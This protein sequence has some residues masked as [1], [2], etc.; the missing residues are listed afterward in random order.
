M[1]SSA[2]EIHFNALPDIT[3]Q[4]LVEAI[5]GRAEPK[6]ILSQTTAGSGAVV[7]WIILMLIVGVIP[8]FML[9]DRYGS[10]YRP[11]QD[12]AHLVGYIV[13]FWL[14]GYSL[15]AAIRRIILD[16][17]MPFKRGRYLFPTELVIATG[18]VLKIY[19]LADMVRFDP[20]HHY[21]NGMYMNTTFNFDFPGRR[22]SFVM[23]GKAEAENVLQMMDQTRWMLSD[24]AQRQDWPLVGQLD[25]FIETRGTDLFAPGAPPIKKAEAPPTEPRSR[26]VPIVLAWASVTALILAMSAIP[27]W[28]VRNYL[29][30]EA[31]FD[32][33]LS[34]GTV[35]CFQDYLRYSSGRHNAEVQ[36]T[37][38]PAAAFREAQ[39]TGTVR[40]LRDFV[41]AY[42]N[43]PQVAQARQVIHQ[44]FES[45]RATF[46]SQSATSDPTMPV[47]MGQLLAWLEQHDSPPV[48]VRFNAP[49]AL[50]LNELDANLGANVSR[51]SPH[52]TPQMC[53]PRE[54]F[55]TTVLQ[56]GF[57]AVFPD[58][59]MHLDHTGRITQQTP[60]PTQNATIDVSYT[61]RPSGAMY[62]DSET[63]R[64]FVGIFNDFVVRMSIPGSTSTHS[65][66]LQVEPPQRFSVGYSRYGTMEGGPS[67]GMVYSVMSERAFDQ[68]GTAL[69]Q[70]F[71]RPDSPAY[72]QAVS[73]QPGMNQPG[74]MNNAPPIPPVIPDLSGL[75]P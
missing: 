8:I 4:R 5:E 53:E 41:V 3:R 70:H 17:A 43:A 32:R 64:Q 71:F 10:L 20:V 46:M 16:R 61:V 56:R 26:T 6:P 45:V 13:L 55:I 19:S 47:F 11:T 59:V 12:A 33:A 74:G 40:A 14:A 2:R 35:D 63:R 29:S 69:P 60:V 39:E 75:T 25:I 57:A 18:P 42:P 9:L 66:I 36:S 24:A 34:C 65:F 27:V 52:F 21:Q 51:I 73:A 7:G 28:A 58:D 48:Q 37:H 1:Q 23:R 30:D 67:D 54:R 62:E 72:Q 22:E 38:L 49:S 68:L 31:S 44:R 50:L 15:L